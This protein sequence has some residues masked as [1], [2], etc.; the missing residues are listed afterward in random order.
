MTAPLDQPDAAPRPW[1]DP[2]RVL[3]RL[4]A[5]LAV[6]ALLAALVAVPTGCDEEEQTNADGTPTHLK[7]E[8]AGKRFNLELAL[9][10][11]QISTGLMHRESLAADGGMLF[12]FPDED[13]RYFWMKNCLIDLD[14]LYLDKSGLIF[15][16]TRMVAP[17]RGTRDRDL[18]H[19]PSFSPAQFAIEL[20][21]GTA[22][23]LGI[24]VGQRV[25]LPLER[26]KELVE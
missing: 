23:N 25:D 18:E 11:E 6:A 20:A 26:L 9:T 13:Y 15:H 16:I 12:V 19:Y 22:D 4:A 1:I 24:E 3:R 7:V 5:M 14:I 2:A 21:A 10:D 8:L 17:E